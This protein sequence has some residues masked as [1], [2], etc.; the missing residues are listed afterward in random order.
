[1][2]CSALRKICPSPSREE[3]LIPV[4]TGLVLSVARTAMR[5]LQG[6]FEFYTEFRNS[7]EAPHGRP[8]IDI[9]RA[10]SAWRCRRIYVTVLRPGRA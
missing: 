7:I 10:T 3:A 5:H 6:D 2:V 9:S 8:C 1:M 4:Q